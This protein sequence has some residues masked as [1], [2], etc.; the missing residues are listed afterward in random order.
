MPT[1][2]LE[3]LL[4]FAFFAIVPPVLAV[5][6]Y[7]TLWHAPRHVARLVL[8]DPAGARYLGAGRPARALAR[9]AGEAAPLTV[10]ALA[11]LFGLLLAVPRPSGDP[12][13]LLAL[14]LVLVSALT[15]PHASLVAYMDARQGIWQRGRPSP[16]SSPGP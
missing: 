4:L 14:Y 3:T 13:S 12:G 11:L 8:L 16:D 5:G 9:F 2:V 10:L 15:L 6:L 7:F 1:V